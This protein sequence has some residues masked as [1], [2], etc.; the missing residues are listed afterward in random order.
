MVVFNLQTHKIHAFSATHNIEEVNY[1]LQLFNT[2]KSIGNHRSY[3][4]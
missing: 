3:R 2:I 1:L 4:S